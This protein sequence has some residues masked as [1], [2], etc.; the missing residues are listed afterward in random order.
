MRLAPSLLFSLLMLMS[1]IWGQAAASASVGGIE[2]DGLPG[3]HHSF[4]T[5]D[6][7]FL[8][9]LEEDD[10][11]EFAELTAVGGNPRQMPTLQACE[12]RSLEMYWPPEMVA[13]QSLP[14]WAPPSSR[15]LAH[16]SPAPGQLLRPPKSLLPA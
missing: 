2:A 1:I 12:D 7:A 5:I 4:V 13:V 9:E 14:V 15:I 6:E 3:I 11:T 16:L 10:E 8:D